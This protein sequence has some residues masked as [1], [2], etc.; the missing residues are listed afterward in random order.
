MLSPYN[1]TFLRNEATLRRTNRM[2]H[3]ERRAGF[4]KKTLESCKKRKKVVDFPSLF[5]TIG[6]LVH[7][8]RL[9]SSLLG[10]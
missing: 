4:C 7:P 8:N 3:E 1:A 6:S 9:A 10:L 2:W 5:F